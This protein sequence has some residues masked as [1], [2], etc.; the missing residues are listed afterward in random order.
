MAEKKL[1]MGAKEIVAS[2]R[3]AKN[4]KAQI[5]V[6]ADLNGCSKKE[7]EEVLVQLGAMKPAERKKPNPRKIN[8][9]ADKA[10]ELLAQ[11]LTD[12]EAAASLGISISKFAEWRREE[13][14]K[15][16][17]KAAAL[18]ETAEQPA[19]S[20]EQPASIEVIDGHDLDYVTVG[21]LYNIL[22][23][24]L[25]GKMGHAAVKGSALPEHGAA[26]QLHHRRGG[27]RAYRGAGG[28]AAVITE[29]PS[30]E[31]GWAVA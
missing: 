28:G 12:E 27:W 7:I 24:A 14:L 25:A 21:K 23:A 13:G 8:V 11:G 29:K 1:P 20:K 9:D 17:R 10:R 19:E 26:D 30:P 3:T 5:G 16:N 18:Q 15:P 31:R 6:L 22:T 2:Y 4:P